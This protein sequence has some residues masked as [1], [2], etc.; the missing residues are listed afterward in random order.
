MIN[1]FVLNLLVLIS[2]SLMHV[3]LNFHLH[4]TFK[5]SS[6]Q[7]KIRILF[8]FTSYPNAIIQHLNLLDPASKILAIQILKYSF[9][10]LYFLLKPET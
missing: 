1:F 8:L 2:T 10:L 4:Q 3:L 9:I 7:L 6:H 5:I